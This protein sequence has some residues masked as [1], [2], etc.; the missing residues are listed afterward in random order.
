MKKIK[1][2]AL[3]L[4]LIMI[5]GT[6]V[7]C[8]SK[9]DAVMTF[10]NNVIDENEYCYML[11]NYK[12]VYLYNLFGLTA[13]NPEIWTSKLS[14][15]VTVND[16]LT[17]LANS[18][19][20]QTILC[21]GLFDEYGLSLSDAEIANIEVQMQNYIT[22]AGSKSALNKMLSAYG[23]NADTMKSIVVDSLKVAKLRSYLYGEN[24][25]AVATDEEKDTYYK[26]NYM[27]AKLIFISAKKDYELD[28]SGNY[29][30]DETTGTYK[31]RDLTEEEK[32]A[33]KALFDSVEARVNAGEDFD[34]LMRAYTM[35]LDMTNYEDG[36]YF[37]SNS[38]FLE[39]TV[40]STVSEMEIGTVKSLTTDSGWYI[41]KRSELRDKAYDDEKY[42]NLMFA[43][44][45]DSIHS[46]KLQ[47]LIEPHVDE[48]VMDKDVMEQ[49]QIAYCTPNFSILTGQITG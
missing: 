13:D 36:Y 35:N 10:K 7:G 19:V 38:S 32:T 8:Q 39:Q 27:C 17:A 21:L 5:V 34:S 37:T 11:S 22:T 47:K 40:I 3:I 23:A 12:A 2:A 29:I 15:D 6:A 46:L 4:A 31:T 48:V 30:L 49:Y 24:G 14:E 20:L 1:F 9:A 42:K 18:T 43:D 45:L 16:Y 28:D 33:K 26:E 41:I 25:I 44:M